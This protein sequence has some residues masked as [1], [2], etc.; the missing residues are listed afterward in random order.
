MASRA[1]QPWRPWQALFEQRGHQTLAPGW[2]GKAD[3]VTATRDD[4]DAVAD[5]GV[6]DVTAHYAKIISGWIGHPS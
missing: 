1:R 6:E 4:P 3:S 2:P 5:H